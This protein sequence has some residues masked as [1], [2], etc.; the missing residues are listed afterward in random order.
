M[1]RCS[2]E[3]VSY[4]HLDVYK[5]QIL[6]HPVY[7]DI[8]GREDFAGSAFH[9][10]RWDHKVPLS[11]KRVGVIGTG[12]TAVQI[13]PAI[14]EDVSNVSLFQ[15]T[16]QWILP[17]PNLPIAEEERSRYRAEPQLMQAQ[18][19]GIAQV[20]NN[21]FGAAL[22]GEN[23]EFYD[24]IA[25]RCRDNLASVRDADLRA[26]LTPNYK[27]GCKRLIV[28]DLFYPAIQRD[29]ATLVTTAIER[30]EATGIRTADGVLH[31]LDILVFA[32]GFD[33]HQLFRPMQVIGRDGRSLDEVWTDGNAAY[34]GISVPGFPNFFMVG[35][36]NSP[37]GNFSFIMTAERQ[38]DYMLQLVGKLQS[39]EAREISV[40]HKPTVTYNASLKERMASSIWASGCQSWYIDKN[41]NVA[42]YPWSYETFERDMR[43]PAFEDFEIV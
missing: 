9:S 41:G 22:I 11:G 34:R 30:I 10:S 3:P 12:S 27:A 20:I 33:P 6:H 15:R 25:Q 29:N 26:R 23:A 36:P 16:A 17:Q 19:D 32:T 42:S 2:S 43:A 14:V 8:A 31:E 38:L 13:L 1:S 4:T 28:S 40:R 37:I 18:Y 39:G 35:G 7:P 5:R 21:V 24:Q